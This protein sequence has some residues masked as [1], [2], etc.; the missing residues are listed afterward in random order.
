MGRLAFYNSD[1]KAEQP[2]NWNRK[3]GIVNIDRTR[4]LDEIYAGFYDEKTNELPAHIKSVA[5]YYEHL[6]APVPIYKTNV[7]GR[8]LVLEERPLPMATEAE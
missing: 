8:W 4:I 1:E 5:D 7:F 2:V 3:E 6:K